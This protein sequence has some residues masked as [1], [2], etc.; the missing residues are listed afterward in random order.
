MGRGEDS[1][2]GQ[3][4]LISSA[5]GPSRVDGQNTRSIPAIAY[6]KN[7]E[8]LPSLFFGPGQGNSGI[9]HQAQIELNRS[10]DRGARINKANTRF[11][12]EFKNK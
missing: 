1:N 11:D 9:N 3:K 12:D 7:S 6:S 8:A 4:Y 2:E 5:E 10:D